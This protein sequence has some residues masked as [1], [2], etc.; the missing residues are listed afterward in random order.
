MLRDVT[1]EGKSYR[2]TAR[3]YDI[4]E[5]SVRRIIKSYVVNGE[6]NAN[7]RGG[8]RASLLNE[9]IERQIRRLMDD[10]NI[11]NCGDIKDICGL[12]F[13]ISTVWRWIKRLGYTYKMVRTIPEMRN[14]PVVKAER[15]EYVQWYM[16]LPIHVRYRNI[17]YIDESPFNLHMVRSHGYAMRG[18]TPN[19]TILNSRGYNVTMILAVNYINLIHSEAIVGSGVNTEIFQGFLTSVKDILGTEEEFIIVMDNVRFHHAN[20]KFFDTYPYS[21]HYLPRYSPFLNPCEE[22][23]SLIKNSVRAITPPNGTDELI[24]RM[25]L[26]TLTLTATELSGYI[27][28]CESFFNNCLNEE[29]IMR[30]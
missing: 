14:D 5:R 2:E 26:G 8:A 20:M 28:H 21:I 3:R 25:R 18:H 29:D 6:I 10:N 1:R 30:E 13:D 4:S 7:S 12:S 11:Y 19:Q 16:S 22:A 23:F 17:I 24:N 27:T 9:N 15:K